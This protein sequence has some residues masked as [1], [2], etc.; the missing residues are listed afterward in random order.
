MGLLIKKKTL[1]V[2]IPKTGGSTMI[3]NFKENNHHCQWEGAHA[4][5]HYLHTQCGQINL[6]P[7]DLHIVS[8]VRNPWTKMFSTWRFFSRLNFTEF[9]SGDESIDTDFNKWVKWVYTDFD[10]NKK[11]R[12]KLKFNMYKYHF[13]EQL[14]WFRDTDGNRLN[15]DNILKTEELTSKMP[16]LAKLYDWKNV[17][18]IV[19]VTTN[20]KVADKITDVINNESIDLIGEA[21]K[22]DLEEFNYDFERR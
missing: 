18:P 8:V 10:R 4:P 12:G 6:N 17:T 9:Y 22:G 21:F 5:L 3:R 19:N 20:K 13:T 2:H 15:V 11:D 14:N 7:D 16:E 1:L